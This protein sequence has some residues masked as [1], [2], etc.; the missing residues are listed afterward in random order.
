MDLE[1]LSGNY[2]FFGRAR[3]VRLTS[4]FGKEKEILLSKKHFFL[5]MENS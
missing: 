4:G 1:N 5:K 3:K 2:D